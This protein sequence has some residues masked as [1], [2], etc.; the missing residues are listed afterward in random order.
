[1]KNQ[2]TNPVLPRLNDK[3]TEV[4]VP[5]SQM[6]DIKASFVEYR[7]QNPGEPTYDSSQGDGGASLPGGVV[8]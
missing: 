3:R 4:S 5:Q 1:M 7:K 8:E 2:R 6:F